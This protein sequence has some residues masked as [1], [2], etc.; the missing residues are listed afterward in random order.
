MFEELIA[1]FEIMKAKG[2]KHVGGAEH[3]IIYGI[4]NDYLSDQDRE[5]LKKHNWHLDSEHGF[6]A[7][8][9]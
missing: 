6:W 7:H 9:V 3:D 2:E 5:A 1:G 8:F 4:H